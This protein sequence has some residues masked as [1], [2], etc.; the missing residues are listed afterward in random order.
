MAT[1]YAKFKYQD[2][3][4]LGIK[5]VR[6]KLFTTLPKSLEPSEFLNKTLEINLKRHLGTKKAKSEQ[7]ITPVLN[8]L[9]E[10]N[11]NELTFFSGYNFDVDK[12]QGLKGHV[13]F[14]LTKDAFSPII[15]APIFCI[16]EAKNDNLDVGIPQCIAEMYAS[17]IFN[18]QKQNSISK[19][20]GT[21]TYGLAW[22]FLCL[23]N[24]ICTIDNDI[25]YL[26]EL[27]KLLGIIQHISDGN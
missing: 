17:K 21:V 26:N 16:V 15:D 5:L 27:P 1:T 19:I 4:E 11:I 3:T 22:Q 12:T 7:I 14:I 23:E 8:E 10:R 20:Y 25:Y 6:Q 13:D 9:V 24:N 2:I 18:E